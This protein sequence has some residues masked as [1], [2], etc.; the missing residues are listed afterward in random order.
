[1]KTFLIF[2]SRNKAYTLVNVL[3]LS[4]SLMFVILI[5]AYTWQEYHVNSQYPK[6]DR[7][8][9]YG[10]NI[11]P[12]EGETEISSG[13]HWRLQQHFKSRYPEIESSCAV[14]GGK[15]MK[16]LYDIDGQRT[17]VATLMTDSTFFNILDIPMV[18]GD[19]RTALN[20]M[21][22]AVV[23]DEFANRI[24]GSPEKAIGRQLTTVDSIHLRITGVMPKIEHSSIPAVDI[25]VRFEKLAGVLNPNLMSEAMNNANGSEILFLERKGAHL[26]G[27]TKDMDEYQKEFFWFFKNAKTYKIHTTLTPLSKFYFTKFSRTALFKYGDPKFINILLAVGIV[28]LL[29]SIFNYINLTNAISDKR[30]R[31]MAM[32]RLVG[33]TRGDVVVRLVSESVMLCAFSMAIAILLAWAAAPYAEKLLTTDLSPA[34]SCGQTVVL[35]FAVVAFTVLLGVVSGIMPASV[36]SSTKPIDI[37]KGTLHYNTHQWLSKAFIIVQNTATISLIAMAFAMSSQIA[38]MI[39]QPRGYNTEN[40]IDIPLGADDSK[41]LN[42]WYDGLKKLPQVVNVTACCGTPHGGGNNNTFEFHDREISSQILKGDANYM[43]VFGLKAT[44]L[45]GLKDSDGNYTYVNRQMLAEEGLPVNSRYFY[46]YNDWTDDDK[47]VPHRDNV[48]GVLDDFTIRG[49]DSE[50]HP[51]YLVIDPHFDYKNQWETV[52]QVQG[53]PVTAYESVRNLFEKTFK[54]PLDIEI[55]F[56]DQQIAYEYKN[57]IRLTTIL[58]LFA[59]IAMVIAVLGLVAMSTYY[60]DGSRKEIAIRKVFG[61]TSGEVGRRFTGRFLSYVVIAF[62]LAIPI[63]IYFYGNWVAGYSHR[64]MWWQWIPAAGAIVLLVSYAAVCLQVRKASRQNPALN[65]KSE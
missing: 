47:P 64:A 51:L 55:P 32:R 38:Y 17:A 6:A 2:L 4:L 22:S 42:V 12:E 31:E 7:I 8:L 34:L 41:G 37:V 15:D 13:G 30:A 53:D 45:T 57:E 20:D 49:I 1:M 28:I 10:N 16:F 18:L 52:I 33:A 40:L 61:A 26:E 65:L 35:V 58:H 14:Y 50:Q 36:I 5:G 54:V 3:G 46:P 11:T 43:K 9:V 44:G 60:I 23:T 29:F 59:F 63:I 24:Y 56:I 48:S 25:I 62:V 21:N 27:K 19:A 39:S